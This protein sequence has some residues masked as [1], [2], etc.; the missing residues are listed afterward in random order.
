[1]DEPLEII[2]TQILSL[3]DPEF[4]IL[5]NQKRHVSTDV[6]KSA[7]FLLV[8]DEGDKATLMRKIYLYVD[9]EIPFNLLIHTR[10][11]WDELTADPFSF[12]YQTKEKGV[13][14]YERTAS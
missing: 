3:C 2:L 5:F 9:S 8:I 6:I 13:V 10:D 14:V 4:V 11:E 1:M 7:D 12:A